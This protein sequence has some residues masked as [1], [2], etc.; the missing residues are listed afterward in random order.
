MKR[1]EAVKLIEETIHDTY[2]YDPDKG[3]TVDAEAVLDALLKEGML[4]PEAF[5]KGGGTGC[6]CT[7]RESCSSC[8]GTCNEWEPEND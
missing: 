5:F 2:D 8:G 1:S 3:W 7:M 4:P 6:L